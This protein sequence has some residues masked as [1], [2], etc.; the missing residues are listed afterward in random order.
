MYIH[1]NTHKHM[2]NCQRGG[3]A[4]AELESQK[5]LTISFS[6]S[7]LLEYS[8]ES[9]N[10]RFASLFCNQKRP[11]ADFCTRKGKWKLLQSAPFLLFS[12]LK[13]KARASYLNHQ[14]NDKS[15][16]TKN[17]DQKMETVSLLV[18]LS[19]CGSPWIFL[20]CETFILLSS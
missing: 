1:I 3:L 15:L 12:Y 5:L 19:C 9:L 7:F 13:I 17:M 20:L 14:T 18:L 2:L 10:S 6:L 16:H 4:N 8:L 11:H